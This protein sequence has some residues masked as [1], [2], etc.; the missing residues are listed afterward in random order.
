M[1]SSHREFLEHPRK[2]RNPR[3][4]NLGCFDSRIFGGKANSQREFPRKIQ[5]KIGIHPKFP[6]ADLGWD[7]EWG[8]T[9]LP[10][11][12]RGKKSFWMGKTEGM[13]EME[14]LWRFSIQ[15]PGKAP[16][17]AWNSHNFHARQQ[18][19]R[20]NWD[21]RGREQENHGKRRIP[22]IPFHYGTGASGIGRKMNLGFWSAEG[23]PG[24]ISREIWEGGKTLGSLTSSAP[25]GKLPENQE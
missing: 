21:R 20:E 15:W 18:R 8:S 16:I 4:R 7:T 17:P 11:N 1:D 22:G 2:G 10:K 13:E 5:H 14:N 23:I 24:C 3:E 12:N 19:K 25:R 6:G 9:F